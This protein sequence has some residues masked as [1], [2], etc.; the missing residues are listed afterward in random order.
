MNDETTERVELAS[1]A[2]EGGLCIVP[3]GGLAEVGMNCMLY[4]L[5]GQILVVDCGVNF[6]EEE[7]YG[8][9]HII[10]SFSYLSANADRVVGLVVTHG[11]E[12]H[13]GAIPYLLRDLNPPVYG[14]PLALAL[15]K[16][17]LKEHGLYE[18]AVLR[19]INAGD[20]ITLGPF[21]IEPIHVNHSI[22][23]TI[24][25]AIDTPVGMVIHTGDFKVDHT[26][27]IDE[28]IDLARFAALGDEGV[29][30]LLSDSTNVECEGTS[31]GEAEV[32]KGLH[33]LIERA[34]GRVLATLFASNLYRVQSFLDIAH[35]VGRRVVMLGRS[36]LQNVA[37]A[38]ELGLIHLPD[39][40][41]VIEPGEM[42]AFRHD[43]I[44]VL[45]TGSQGE[46]RSALNRIAM[47]DHSLCQL[48][49]GDQVI[50]SSRVIPG[51]EVGINRVINHLYKRGA[52]VHQSDRYS[53]HASGHA[54]REEQ[55]LMLSLTQP[56]FFVPVHGE[57]RMLAQHA[58]LA[59][60]MGVE[61][62]FVL[63]N[64]DILVLWEDSGEVVGR[65]PA[66]R[67][68]VDGKGTDDLPSVVLQDRRKLARTGIVVAW[69]VLDVNTGEIVSGPNLSTHGVIG[70]EAG[71]DLL[72]EAALA[73]T[74]AIEGLST[75]S[76]CESSEVA[77]TMRIA[78][79]RVFNK[80]IESKPVVV[81]I[82]HEL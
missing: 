36:L 45:A 47:G 3:L 64:G 4:E 77:E 7:D 59:K 6:P 71:D 20:T 74:K 34:P 42:E 22:P 68:L 10:P 76:R 49:P 70:S 40:F 33:E 17:K 9:D 16:R 80:R 38:R 27:G 56:L 54:H 73:A 66:G 82:V 39:E 12:D 48:I 24:S 14:T 13:I 78:V 65:A 8:I 37:V 43:Q 58:A 53:V 26:P 55:K 46:P 35:A 57:Y 21:E 69:L 29:L 41:I 81:P 30:C 5:E 2:V 11:H 61:D 19:E 18:H 31:K 60:S 15:I 50:F 23:Q 63:A 62:T 1:G 25:L 51:N 75:E 67:V 32:R 44:L 28:P 72:E 79:R 52:K